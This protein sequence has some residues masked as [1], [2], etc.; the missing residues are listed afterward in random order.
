[1]L[2]GPVDSQKALHKH[3]RRPEISFGFIL[4]Q[5]LPDLSHE[6]CIGIAS[7]SIRQGGHD[8]VLSIVMLS[9]V[10]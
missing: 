7:G 2:P 5:R 9:I 10:D 1:M 4:Q 8:I 3:W 6:V